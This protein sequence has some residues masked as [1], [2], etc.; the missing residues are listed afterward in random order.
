[1]KLAQLRKALRDADPAAV[2]VSPRVLSRIIEEVYD[3]PNFIWR[4]PHRKSCVVDR[5][6][7][8]RH[9][10]QEEL[11]LEADRLL[12]NTV[13]LLA[14]PA[15]DETSAA[16]PETVLVT[17]WQRLFHAKIH[18]TLEQ[19]FADGTLTE[20]DLDER[21]EAIG[22]SEFAEIR[23]VLITEHYLLGNA[24]PRDLY[25][26]FAAVFLELRYFA[27]NLLPGY[28][29]GIGDLTRIERML[30]L[31]VEAETLHRQ[32]R[33]AGA[34]E[35]T[36]PLDTTS[37]EAHEFFR[38]LVADSDAESRRGN[39][40]K[41]AIL[42]TQATRVAP[43]DRFAGTHAEA[44]Q[45]LQQL[46][47]RLRVALELSDE[48]AAEWAKA[49]PILLDK[50][51]QGSSPVEAALL[52]DLQ[53]VCLD[54]EQEIYALDLVE[55][56]LSAGRR[57]IKRPLPSQRLVR[58]IR[59][60]R[61]ATHRLTR[62]RL[63]D[64][65]RARFAQLLDAAQERCA[66][67]LRANFRPVLTTALHDVGFESRNP[68]ERA[69][70]NKIIEEILDRIVEHGF[71]TF[72]DLRDTL[73][74]SQLKLPDLSDP[75]EFILG[76]PLLRLD[77]RLKTLL[78][79]VY[80]PSEI[81]SRWL[82]R[83]TALNFG[84]AA[85]RLLTLFVTV[86]FGG[87]FLLLV[88]L[89]KLLEAVRIEQLP[90]LVFWPSVAI[91][92]A[93]LL[94]LLHSPGLRRWFARLGSRVLGGV[95]TVCVD[96]PLALVRMP[97]L[98]R[99]VHSW[100]FQLFS[101]YLIKPL[102]LWGLLWFLVPAA[103]EHPVSA[104]AIFLGVVLLVNSQ[105]GHALNEFINQS[106][107]RLLELLRAGLI[108]GLVR[109]V[110]YVF[111]KIIELMEKALFVVDEFLRFRAG[112]GKISMVARTILGL[113]WFPI[114]YVARF[115]LVVLIEPGFNPI[116]FPISSI[117]AK[118]VYPLSPIITGFLIDIS[119]PLLGTFL[120][121][122]VFAPTT[123]FLLPDAFG[124][125]VWEMKENWSLYQ[126]N[127]PR[128]LRPVRV[129]TH[130]ETVRRLLQP[131]FHSGTIPRLFAHLRQAERKARHTGNWGKPRAYQRDLLEV[132]QAVREFV[133]RDLVYLV[134]QAA[135]WRGYEL[136][137][138]RISLTIN[139]IVIALSH[140]GHPDRNLLLEFETSSG[141]LVACVRAS[142]WLDVLTEPQ[143]VALSAALTSFYKYAGVDLVRE[144]VEQRLPSAAATYDI[145]QSAL[146]LRPNHVDGV[147]TRVA[148]A[149]VP[150]E[151]AGPPTAERDFH[152]GQQPLSWQQ[153]W[154]FWQ[155]D[156]D[157][158]SP[159]P[160]PLEVL[161]KSRHVT[162][163]AISVAGSASDRTSA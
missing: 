113:I 39:L 44:M 116:K 29:P 33:L 32:T 140:S 3:L 10:E 98:R 147:P 123:M 100:V 114:A 131:G 34:P 163:A 42:R 90:Q 7:L 22:V 133:S 59:H 60:L 157:Q 11:N 160:W 156:Q 106:L 117:A 119:E 130:G 45:F 51:D 152:F 121:H 12:P 135:S 149:D 13:I 8:F 102:V 71:L 95:R 65:D 53:R 81:Y 109:F 159:P 56:V 111:K 112:D 70:F 35:V 1:M 9:V 141:W 19:R 69:A 96:V 108:P 62:A 91:L 110:L 57:P 126:S 139:R 41:A 49:L 107:V 20:R 64:A 78:D 120:S 36:V 127:R 40:V 151:L 94:Y 129:G 46:L 26:E 150:E 132:E 24:G 99:I 138:G 75:Q 97:P 136:S 101:W 52:Y 80:R 142:G 28:F 6:L 14:R 158:G 144:Q 92:G 143:V 15:S 50:A 88:G 61:S 63:S 74:R 146:L 27:A 77:R 128:S 137:V 76:D 86:P 155:R 47:G 79:G 115:Y 16:A 118:L 21:I 37:D 154:D 30:A 17:Y 58:V 66:Q 85:G 4:V 54:S 162:S 148:L 145:T 43:G 93:F 83:F 125:L 72:S 23:Q 55:W 82:E 48:E 73:S 104:V 124:F 84:T 134:N 25:I 5:Q 161:P 68:L 18:E 89:N 122:Y 31:D 67:R 87:A 105:F 2:L 153:C 103:F 38:A